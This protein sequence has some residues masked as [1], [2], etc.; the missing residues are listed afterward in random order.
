MRVL[1]LPKLPLNFFSA[2]T[3]YLVRVDEEL[4]RNLGCHGL[5]V[6]VGQCSVFVTIPH[7]IIS[8]SA[9]LDLLHTLE[10]PQIC[11]GNPASDFK[12]LVEARNGIFKDSSGV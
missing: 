10:E 7:T 1:Y 2:D 5:L 11:C 4:R 9:L 6:E 3:T 8:A 12:S